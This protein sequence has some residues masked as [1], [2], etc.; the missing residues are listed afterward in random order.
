MAN[1]VHTFR[2]RDVKRVICATQQ[3]G[4]KIAGVQVNP[5]TGDITI[6]TTSK[7]ST[8]STSVKRAGDGERGRRHEAF[9]RR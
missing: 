2:D 8:E 7:P 4:V 5:R 6:H 1:R 3:A 9:R